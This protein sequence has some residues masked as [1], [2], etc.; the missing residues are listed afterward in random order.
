MSSAA[1]SE[2]A[3]AVYF[4]A[5][6][7][8]YW[9]LGKAGSAKPTEQNCAAA[10]DALVDGGDSLACSPVTLAEF[11]STLWSVAR[12][13]KEDVG[14][15]DAPAAASAVERLMTLIGS[16]RIKVNNLRP[17]A[18]EVGI[19]IVGVGSREKQKTFNAFDAIHLYEAC[20]WARVMGR[21]VVIATSDSDFSNIIATFP[22][23][24]RYVEVRDLT[25]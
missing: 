19:A 9:A 18:F 17:R 11:T 15:F 13:G 7:V 1:A 24:G 2:M 16:G 21:K 23:F 14:Y 10:F 4:D 6:P 25:K 8:L 5:N 20:Q 3:D 22:E 12:S